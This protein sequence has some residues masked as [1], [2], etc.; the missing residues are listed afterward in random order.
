VSRVASQAGGAAV[1]VHRRPERRKQLQRASQQQLARAEALLRGIAKAL[2][3]KSRLT[4][5]DGAAAAPLARASEPAAPPAAVADVAPPVSPDAGAA[6][7]AP[8]AAAHPHASAHAA[9]I[10]GAHPRAGAAPHVPHAHYAYGGAPTPHPL[11]G[12]ADDE[13]DLW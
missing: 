5:A 10:S 3:R 13:D 12:V 2:P 1:Y 9:A 6:P 7:L 8:Y 4:A 11:R